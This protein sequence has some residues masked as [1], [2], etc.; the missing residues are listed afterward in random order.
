[1]KQENSKKTASREVQ[2]K[3]TNEYLASFLYDLAKL[4]F[5]TLVV[6][7]VVILVSQGDEIPNESWF[8]VI[9]GLI[10]TITLALTARNQLSK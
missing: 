5:A 3:T 1:M 10:G 9:T 4:V 8:L 2:S 7:Q 6:G